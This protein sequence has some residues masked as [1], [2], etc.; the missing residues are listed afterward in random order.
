MANKIQRY[1]FQKTSEK[2]QFLQ[3]EVFREGSKYDVGDELDFGE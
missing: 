3:T 2:K 1:T